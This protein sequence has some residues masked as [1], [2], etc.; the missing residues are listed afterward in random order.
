LTREKIR[1][2]LGGTAI[3][4]AKKLGEGGIRLIDRFASEKRGSWAVWGGG[5]WWGGLVCDWRRLGFST[6]AYELEKAVSRLC[7]MKIQYT[8]AGSM[9]EEQAGKLPE[10]MGTGSMGADGF[11]PHSQKGSA[12]VS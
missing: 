9:R 10:D 4:T 1:K 11:L 8:I 5:G 7:T 12:L 6:N 3:S 2:I